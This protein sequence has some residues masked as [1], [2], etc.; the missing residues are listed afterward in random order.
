[1]KIL[2]PTLKAAYVLS[3]AAVK[4]T[5]HTAVGLSTAAFW[6]GH[7]VGKGVGL[8]VDLAQSGA[9]VSHGRL[10]CPRG[11]VVDDEGVWQCGACGYTWEGLPWRCPHVECGAQTQFITCPTCGLSVRN[12][13]R[14]VS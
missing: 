11:H 3:K 4:V 13:R 5:W 10:L 1:M 2:G 9:R 7:A 14:W 8:A 6:T 12:P